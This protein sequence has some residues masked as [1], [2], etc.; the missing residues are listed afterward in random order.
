MVDKLF[1]VPET[2]AALMQVDEDVE[3][4]FPPRWQNYCRAGTEDKLFITWSTE[5]NMLVLAY[6]G[7][8]GIVIDVCGQ[9]C[10]EVASGW[11]LFTQP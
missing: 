9:D 6:G 10:I 4:W 8:A 1:A 3:S 11:V 7:R 2:L 5:G